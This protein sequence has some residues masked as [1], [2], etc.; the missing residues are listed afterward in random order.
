MPDKVSLPRLDEIFSN[1]PSA[2]W[3]SSHSLLIGYPKIP[4]RIEDRKKTAFLTQNGI[5]LF[6]RMPCA[7]CNARENFQRLMDCIFR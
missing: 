6:N 4:V 5:I 7:L 1:H 3:V 2:H